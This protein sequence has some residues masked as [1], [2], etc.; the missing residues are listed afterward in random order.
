MS[1][2]GNKKLDPE[3]V[4]LLIAETTDVQR[5]HPEVELLNVSDTVLLRGAIGFDM[6]VEPERITDTYQIMMHFP[7]D[8]PNSPPVTYETGGA[9][10]ST[11]EHLFADGSCCLG[12]P[13]E[14]R[15]R[16]LK[17][18]RLLCFVNEQVL[19]FL[20]SCT[21]WREHGEM[22]FGELAHGDVGLLQYYMEFFGVD[23]S[24][25]MILL[26]LLADNIDAPLM[27]CPCRSGAT[28]GDCHGQR[29]GELRTALHPRE[30]EDEL[31]ALIRL[32]RAIDIP[33]PTAALPRRVL[34]RERKKARRRPRRTR[35]H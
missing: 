15:R 19:P 9:I 35:R 16:F 10:P 14:V 34:R 26:K 32:V 2:W 28:F 20:Y 21:Y 22:P 13:A 27:K 18:R 6:G 23:L 17:H 11:F 25:T 24:A 4:D 12:A 30:Y 8:Y 29:I 1:R 5:V 7:A 33:V 31:L 3:T